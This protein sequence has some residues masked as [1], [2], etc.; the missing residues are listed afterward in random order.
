MDKMQIDVPKIK[1]PEYRV[2][3]RP[4]YP[5]LP[6]LIPTD[7]PLTLLLQAYLAWETGRRARKYERER[8]MV[9][10]IEMAKRDVEILKK[11]GE[12][13]KIWTDV[14]KM[15]EEIGKEREK[16]I[17]APDHLVEE[18]LGR[19]SAE[20][21]KEQGIR[22]PT[23]FLP[24]IAKVRRENRQVFL[25]IDVISR[26]VEAFDKGTSL[27][28]ALRDLGIPDPTKEEVETAL[29]ISK[30]PIESLREKE[31]LMKEQIANNLEKVN[32]SI[33]KKEDFIKRKEMEVAER[34]TKLG[35]Q[36]LRE[37]INKV[38]A[39]VE[40]DKAQIW[41]W[42]QDVLAEIRKLNFNWAKLDV[43]KAKEN[44]RKMDAS[45]KKFRNIVSLQKAI[46][47]LSELE[48]KKVEAKNSEK[49]SKLGA[50]MTE[51]DSLENEGI[52]RL[53]AIAKSKELWGKKPASELTKGMA[54]EYKGVIT[55]FIIR[56]RAVRDEQWYKGLVVGED[57]A[58]KKAI[59]IV[60]KEF[61]KKME[62][63]VEK[64][65][66]SARELYRLAPLPV[67]SP[68]EKRILERGE[69]LVKKE[70]E[71]FDLIT[72][73]KPPVKEVPPRRLP[74][75][76]VPLRKPP[77]KEVAPDRKKVIQ[78]LRNTYINLPAERRKEFVGEL[79]GYLKAK[80]LTLREFSEIITGR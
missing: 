15:R 43:E 49:T 23:K 38:K 36:K 79:R 72:P 61:V 8:E 51:L 25:D 71:A 20:K 39:S 9:W 19:E 12:V 64:L 67:P 76:E 3:A 26:L 27:H 69:E 66:E 2:P 73:L 33:R 63:R 65:R 17:P 56:A 5:T 77:V 54:K 53:E 6:P 57:M 59:N 11:M 7:D 75:K 55:N 52:S 74:V 70:L 13:D 37:E 62:E 68:T 78:R 30:F 4:A 24:E 47:G 28:L 1:L 45:L 60:Y 80:E 44:L 46:E 32:L 40:K 18:Y 14:V 34:K 58:R 16:W 50:R 31:L 21:Y 42:E 22:I 10:D 48:R 35:I 41:K 29:R